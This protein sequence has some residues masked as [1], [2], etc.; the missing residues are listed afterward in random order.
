MVIVWW[1]DSYTLDA[2]IT[3]HHDEMMNITGCL[4]HRR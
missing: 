4:F 2:A 3:N 1:I